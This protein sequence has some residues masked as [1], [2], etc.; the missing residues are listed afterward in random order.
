MRKK[1]EKEVIDDRFIE[2]LNAY[3]D[4]ALTRIDQEDV[5]I[6]HNGEQGELE[7]IIENVKPK[8]SRITKKTTN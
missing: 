7:D 8:L 2:P 3:K 5:A 4:E 1:Q 6:F